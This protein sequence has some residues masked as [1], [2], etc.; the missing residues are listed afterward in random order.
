M[1]PQVD[2]AIALAERLT[3]AEQGQAVFGTMNFRG[4]Y[5]KFRAW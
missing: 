2:R 3:G 4:R 5:V 1:L